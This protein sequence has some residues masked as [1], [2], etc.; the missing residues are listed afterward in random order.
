VELAEGPHVLAE[1]VDCQESNLKI[2]MAMELALRAVKSVDGSP[3]KM[4]YKWRPVSPPLA[5]RHQDIP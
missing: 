3:E 1:V 4:V 2:G 5:R